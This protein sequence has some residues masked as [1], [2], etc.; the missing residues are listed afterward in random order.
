MFSFKKQKN[1]LD[2]H[3]TYLCIDVGT[4][5]LKVI[6]FDIVDRKVNVL[7]YVKS[8]QHSAAMKNGTVTSIRRVIENVHETISNLK[9]HGTHYS[10][11]I[12]GIAGEL[13]QGVMVEGKYTR[14]NSAKQIDQNEIKLVADKIL[15]EAFKEAQNLVFNQ[16]GETTGELSNIDVINY[17]IVDAEIDGFRVEDPIGLTGSEAKIKIYFTFAPVLHINYLKSITD[18]ININLLGIVPQPFAVARAVKGAREADFSAIIIDVGG[19]TTDIAVVQNGVALDNKMIAFG[20]RVFTKRIANDLKL[21]INEA[22][23]FKIKYSTG[24]LTSSRVNEVRDAINKDTTLWPFS[25]YIGLK[26]FLN[27]VSGFPHKMYLCGGGSLLPEIKDS[28]VEFPWTKELPFNRSP[29]IEYLK[30]EN[31]DNIIDENNLL[32][33]TDD[34]TPASIAC[35]T[36]ELLELY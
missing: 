29:K 6:A 2:N 32:H 22:E 10:G 8:R 12:M 31:I 7:D 3:G 9:T 17:V 4:E 11:A 1:E 30:P 33:G 24:E 25:V 35:F 27:L 26:E 13:V 15:D 23:E 16:I 34:V 20:G 21:T 36:L 5:F 18:S 28:L 19:G 14:N